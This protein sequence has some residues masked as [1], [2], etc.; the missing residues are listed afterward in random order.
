MSAKWWW[1]IAGVGIVV[2]AVAFAIGY[3][4]KQH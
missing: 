4:T 3:I 2:F 1:I